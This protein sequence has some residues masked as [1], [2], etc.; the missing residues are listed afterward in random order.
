MIQLV[1]ALLALFT[2]GFAQALWLVVCFVFML[3]ASLLSELY[4]LGVRCMNKL[5]ELASRYLCHLLAIGTL[6]LI[7]SWVAMLTCNAEQ[8]ERIRSV[9]NNAVVLRT[10]NRED[11]KR[12]E[13]RL[14]TLL[15]RTPAKL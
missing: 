12:I 1:K 14:D 7:G 6:A 15:E 3:C 8:N 11:H 5:K 10:E 9:E 2:I 4:I 13:E